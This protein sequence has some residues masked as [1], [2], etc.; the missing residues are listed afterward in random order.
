MQPNKK[1]KKKQTGIGKQKGGRTREL[2]PGGLTVFCNIGRRGASESR[3]LGVKV[4]RKSA[5]KRDGDTDC[6]ASR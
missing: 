3:G 1:L 4:K 2:T 6:E 5:L